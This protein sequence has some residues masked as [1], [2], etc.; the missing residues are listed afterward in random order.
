MLIDSVNFYAA[1]VEMVLRA[2]IGAIRFLAVLQGAAFL[3]LQAEASVPFLSSFPQSCTAHH[4]SIGVLIL[5]WGFSE[6]GI[7]S[8]GAIRAVLIPEKP[9]RG[10]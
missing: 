8:K 2:A 6:A 1:H 5:R 4:N 7:P 9:S 10:L 3:F